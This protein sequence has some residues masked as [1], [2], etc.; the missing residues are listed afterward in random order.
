MGESFGRYRLVDDREFMPYI[1]ECNIACGF[2]A[3]DPVVIEQTI[4]NAI[5]YKLKIGAHPSFP[6]LQGFGRRNMNIPATD[7]ESMI[8]FQ[9]AG[10]KGVTESFGYRLNHVKAHGALYNMAMTDESMAKAIVKAVLSFGDQI[11][12]FAPHHSAQAKVAHEMGLHVRYEAFIDRLYH[13]DLRL[14]SRHIA[15]ALITDPSIAVAQVESIVSNQK[16]I[17]FENQACEIKANTLCIHGDNPAA[18][19]ILKAL[20]SQSG[21]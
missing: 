16:V 11:I 12:L 6:D 21:N 17:S 20:K 4:R 2:H 7:L 15:G 10:I 8:R 13:K 14:V 3:G 9:I 18:M 19:E 5:E 1:D